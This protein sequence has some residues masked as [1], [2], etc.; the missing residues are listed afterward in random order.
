MYRPPSPCYEQELVIPQLLVVQ[1]PSEHH[2]LHVQSAV[3]VWH[4]RHEVNSLTHYTT[5]S[6][7]HCCVAPW[8]LLSLP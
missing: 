5:N 6:Q 4:A 3:L 2:N 1:C 8:S 7:L